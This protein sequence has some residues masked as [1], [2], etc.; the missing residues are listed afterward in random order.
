MPHPKKDVQAKK[1]FGKINRLDK[2]WKSFVD[3]NCP[4]SKNRLLLDKIR[5]EWRT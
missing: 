2:L 1:L 5:P 4:I 3:N